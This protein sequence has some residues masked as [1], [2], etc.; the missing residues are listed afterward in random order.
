MTEF[1][2]LIRLLHRFPLFIITGVGAGLIGYFFREAIR[3]AGFYRKEE[4]FFLLAL[5][6]AG[7]VIFSLYRSFRLEKKSG[8]LSVIAAVRDGRRLSWIQLPL[9]FLA[10]VLTHLVGGSAGR[11]GGVLEMGGV[12]GDKAIS[13]LK[14]GRKKKQARRR[15][16]PP[17][18]EDVGNIARR[19]IT[20]KDGGQA[21]PA[22]APPCAERVGN[23]ARRGITADERKVAILCGMSS[24][25]SALFVTP[26][27]AVF[28]VLEI[29][30]KKEILHRFVPV[31]I[32]SMIA[33]G[34]V[35]LLGWGPTRH[36]FYLPNPLPAAPFVK[37]AILAAG[38]GLVGRVFC[39][40]MRRTPT[41]FQRVLKNGYLRG[42]AGGALILT[43][44]ILLGT[45]KFN[46]LGEETIHSAF[47]GQAEP[48][49]F[50]WKMIFT[51]MT[52]GAGFKGGEI[53]P[54]FF[55]GSTFG[56]VFAGWIGFLPDFGGSLGSVAI[57]AA[58]AKSPIAAF[59]LGVELFGAEGTL[60]FALAAFI[61]YS[62][63]G[64]AGLYSKE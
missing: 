37:T 55:V 8:A 11:E 63:S 52:V 49:D 17:C 14:S 61:S 15:G 26:L 18:A 4:P 30:D 57:L 13:F 64:K 31:F 16:A 58:V 44:T 29:T 2:R 42:A 32:S 62:V 22:G 60:F 9:V 48:L 19:G 25:F 20:E 28:F 43:M 12:L 23:F 7:I 40:L 34:V 50:F 41:V 54:A 35:C 38:C 24:A 33:F 47:S 51:A 6:I 56:A 36:P 59:V 27:A 39:L 53:I 45:D 10:S 46:G 21:R 1:E 3:L 5:P